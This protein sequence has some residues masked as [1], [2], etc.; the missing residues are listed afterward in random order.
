MPESDVSPAHDD[1]T[2]E[3]PRALRSL[4]VAVWVAEGVLGLIALTLTLR[5]G[6]RRAVV[7]LLAMV[8]LLVAYAALRLWRRYEER[9]DPGRPPDQPRPTGPKS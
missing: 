9:P 4:G 5:F 3:I 6:G 1:S 8:V 7:V 2:T